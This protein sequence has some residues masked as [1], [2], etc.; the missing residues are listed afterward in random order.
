MHKLIPSIAALFILL[1]VTANAG[2]TKIIADQNGNWNS[3]TTWNLDAVPGCYD[4]IVIPA[5]IT[6][7]ITDMVDL[8]MCPPVYIHVQGTLFFQA[9][10]KMD[11]SDGSVVYMAPGGSL[12]GGGG[13]GNSNWI[14]ID[15][16]PY[17]TAGDGNVSGPAY[18]CQNC[19]LPVELVSFTTTLVGG[20]VV[21]EWSTASELNNDYYLIQRSPDGFNWQTIDTT[22]GAGNSSWQLD[23]YEED[24]EPLLGL[25]YYRLKQ[26]DFNGAF[27]YSPI[28]VVSNGNFFTNQDLLV[29]SGQSLTQQN[30][31]IYFSEA[32][33]G[34]VEIVVAT[35]HGS[36]IARES[37]V[38]EDEKWVVIT[39]DQAL[40]SGIYVIKANQK[41]EKSF[42]Q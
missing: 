42:F 27:A 22:D 8:T 13:S 32:I 10:K 35:I 23:Y 6:V 18:L 2:A 30:I 12:Q 20:E 11:L 29:L 40:A 1:F 36:I 9:G 25:S 28:R 3:T 16:D 15:G 19:S 39:V 38:L 31:V 34:P 41:V 7:T 26:V 21:I 24:R 5:G 37:F 14:T 4:T 33:T 17:W